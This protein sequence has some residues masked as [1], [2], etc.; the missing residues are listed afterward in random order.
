MK[1]II[2]IVV[3]AAA[4]IGVGI[5]L[6]VQDSKHPVDKDPWADKS[7]RDLALTCLDQEYTNQHIH[8]VLSITIDGAKQEIP[9]NIG[10]ESPK[11][12][13]ST[14]DAAMQNAGCLNPLH[15]H[16]ATGT[17]HVESP[18]ARDYTLGDFFAVW[19]KIFSK[20]Q[21]F[22][23]KVDDTHRI[24]FVVDGKDNSEFG[25]VVLKDQEKIEI[26][27]EKK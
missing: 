15:T 18:V 10:I 7:T 16:D 17:I 6:S 2:V 23:S 22:D 19:G 27:Y 24:R 3:V 8:P 5:F 25:G 21:I 4:V 26:F 14:H 20:D 11:G 12:D 13:T 9:A 1:K